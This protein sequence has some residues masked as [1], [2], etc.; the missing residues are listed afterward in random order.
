MPG[1]WKASAKALR[2]AGAQ[3]TWQL[4]EKREKSIFIWDDE[5]RTRAKVAGGDDTKQ[6]WAM[7]L[8][9]GI[10]GSEEGNL[11]K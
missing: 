4:A 3:Q 8:P 5:G 2:Q 7:S 10:A 9:D 6:A 1:R 11:Q